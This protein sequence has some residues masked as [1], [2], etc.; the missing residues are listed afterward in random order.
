M[1]SIY[2]L[3]RIL[4]QIG[5]GEYVSSTIATW[6]SV[7]LTT[8]TTANVTSITLTSGEWDVTGVVDYTFGA[9]TSYTIL[10]QGISTTTA[11][12]WGQDTF[13]R[14]EVVA[15][16]PTAAVDPA[17]DLPIVRLVLTTPTTVYLVVNAT[18]SISTLK[19]YGTL[20]ARRIY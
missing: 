5:P 12:M 15:T 19:A 10:Q 16:V 17:V 11:T 4:R 9:T 18:F 3:K 6:S 13:S 1:S 7:S 2:F 14:S 20:R 8:A